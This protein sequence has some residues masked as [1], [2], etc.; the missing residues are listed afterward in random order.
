MS[1]ADLPPVLEMILWGAIA[2]AAMTG[3]MQGAQGMGFSRLSIPFMVGT[4]FSSDRR[5]A[6]VVGF[7]VYFLGGWIFAFVYFLILT[8]LDLLTWWAGGLLGLLHGLLLLV[9]ALPLFPLIHPRMTSDFDAPVARP[10]LEPP[11]FLGLH[12]GGG[13]PATM[14]IAQGL[15]GALIGGLP[16]VRQ[17]V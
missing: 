9:A 8:S 3:L 16:Q 12:Y 10:V 15:Y 13:T 11:G 5:I 14:L 6:T 2:T 4:I 17:I 7:A 1:L